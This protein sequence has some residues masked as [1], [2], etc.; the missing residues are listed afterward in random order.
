MQSCEAWSSNGFRYRGVSILVFLLATATLFGQSAPN[1]VSTNGQP[2]AAAPIHISF[3]TAIKKSVAYLQT[4]CLQDDGKTV[5][6]FATAFFV[7]KLDDRLEKDQG[8][9]YL[10]TNRH[11]AQPGIERGAPCRVSNYWLRV[12]LRGASPSDLPQA[13][14][15]ALGP[16]V[17]WVFPDDPAVD[18]AIVP[19]APD[20][21]KV[22]YEAIPSTMFATADVVKANNIGEGDVV[23]FTGLFVQ[24]PGLL[25][26]E[27]I[28]RQGTI[29]MIP[30]EPIMTTMKR[31]GNLY[32]ADIHVFGGNSGSPMFVNLGGVRNGGLMMGS[33][34]KLLG[35][36]SGYEFEDT[37]FNLQ[38]AT[39]Y[40]GTLGANSGVTSIVP[41]A[42][43]DKL[44]NSPKLQSMRDAVIAR[45]PK[46]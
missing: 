15:G 29:A 17:P 22:D 37:D 34:Y 4:D 42:E 39:T 8:F 41:A 13:T 21:T 12:N 43:L 7:T 20:Q 31:P 40:S 16:G 36:V 19:L 9:G 30:S 26:L 27:P 45:L 33:N 35:V 5:S 6:Y 3:A 44:I 23:I 46:K 18:L 38:A 10:V 28:V 32:L 24:M 25:R 1:P 2:V 14:S 11:A